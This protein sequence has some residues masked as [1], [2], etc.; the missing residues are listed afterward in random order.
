MKKSQP[1]PGQYIEVSRMPDGTF[2]LE[3]SAD[4]DNPLTVHLPAP[5][6]VAAVIS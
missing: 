5:C 2:I 4:P 1:L 6:Q 3:T